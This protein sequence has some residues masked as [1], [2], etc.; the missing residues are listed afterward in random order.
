MKCSIADNEL[1]D[2]LS[3][4]LDPVR[5]GQFDAHLSECDECSLVASLIRQVKSESRNI[6]AARAVVSE[7]KL[8]QEDQSHHPSVGELAD[9][10]YETRPLANQQEV[11]AHVAICAECS[12][13]LSQHATAAAVALVYE[14][15]EK[16]E[17]PE[18]AWELIREW[19]E[20]SFAEPRAVEYR[21]TSEMAEHMLQLFEEKRAEIRQ[22]I[23]GQAGGADLMPVVIVDKAGTYRR[24]ELFRDASQ[25]ADALRLQHT[26]GSTRFHGG[27]LHAVLVSTAG[28]YSLSSARIQNDSVEIAEQGAATSRQFFIVE[29]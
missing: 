24:V 1:F 16:A 25:T 4:R 10:F 9:L 19:E 7:S 26:E 6:A 22:A 14:P 17:A 2:S 20:S 21:H 5:A 13:L 23:S 18:A 3:G 27:L 15:G 29:D 11:A 12:D 8:E 28:G